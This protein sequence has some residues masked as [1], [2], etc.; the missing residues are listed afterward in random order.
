MERRGYGL[1]KGAKQPDPIPGYC[2]SPQ[3]APAI[4]SPAQ[5]KIFADTQNYHKK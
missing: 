1:A 5:K 3:L 4:L 2:I